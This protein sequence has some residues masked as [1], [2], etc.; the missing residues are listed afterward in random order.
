MNDESIHG[1][2]EDIPLGTDCA[3]LCTFAV[4]FFFN[5]IGLLACMC[6]IRSIAGRFGALSGFG[7]SL[8]KWVVIIKQSNWAGEVSESDAWLWWLLVV[9]GC[10]I[11]F[12][13]CTQYLRLKHQWHHMT[14]AARQR[15]YMYF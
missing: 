12:R 4:C 10:L 3:F 1:I 5:W 14:V 2:Y 8:V 11:F 9:V 7:L 13:G 6:F 15:V